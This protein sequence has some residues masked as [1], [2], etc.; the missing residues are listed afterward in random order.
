M[1]D[2]V[3]SDGEDNERDEADEG[4]AVPAEEDEEH[5]EDT[6]AG[7]S[8]AAGESAPLCSLREWPDDDL[9]ELND[10]NDASLPPASVGSGTG[11]L[12][13]LRKTSE[14]PLAGRQTVEERPH[15][16]QPVDART[17]EKLPT[18]THPAE[19][20]RRFAPSATGPLATGR[21]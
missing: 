20:R 6:G 8:D 11:A 1:P 17:P 9:D 18:G 14:A 2:Q 3:D 19:A 5:S 4:A 10:A 15:R 12:R 16:K 21:S 13:L 7:G